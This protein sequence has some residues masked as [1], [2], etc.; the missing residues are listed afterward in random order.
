MYDMNQF[1]NKTYDRLLTIEEFYRQTPELPK[2]NKEKPR[3]TVRINDD[4]KVKRDDDELS[5]KGAYIEVQSMPQPPAPPPRILSK[6]SQLVQEQIIENIEIITKPKEKRPISTSTS[7]KSQPKS[8]SNRP[9]QPTRKIS[10]LN[11]NGSLNESITREPS[12]EEKNLTYLKRYIANGLKGKNSLNKYQNGYWNR[13]PNKLN[14]IANDY[15]TIIRAH[16][17]LSNQSTNTSEHSEYL[18]YLKPIM[19]YGKTDVSLVDLPLNNTNS[20]KQ[21]KQLINSYQNNKLPNV[22][23]RRQ[24]HNKYV[25]FNDNITIQLLNN[26]NLNNSQSINSDKLYIHGKRSQLFENE[27]LE[28]NMIKNSFKISKQ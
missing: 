15:N 7:V 27:D 19:T 17:P 10:A 5:L 6:Q 2:V 28:N 22:Y 21:N 8:S 24:A 4:L 14:I 25:K 12:R 1:M 16:S 23:Y 20:G 13:I 18:R 26:N 9:L 3:K 11:L